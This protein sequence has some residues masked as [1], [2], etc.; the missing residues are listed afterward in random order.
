M[1]LSAPKTN[2]SLSQAGWSELQSTRSVAEAHQV[3]RD[4]E[5]RGL[6]HVKHFLLSEAVP[7]FY[8]SQSFSALCP[9][10]FQCTY[11]V[12]EITLDTG[13]ANV[14]VI[15]P[16]CVTFKIRKP[17][18]GPNTSSYNTIFIMYMILFLESCQAIPLNS[19]DLRVVKLY[20]V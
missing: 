11:C 10:I 13:E 3:P 9:I 6:S 8:L 19:K 15:T 7:P 20:T 2:D 12:P 4:C 5:G 16:F 17:Y 1:A 18:I 14:N